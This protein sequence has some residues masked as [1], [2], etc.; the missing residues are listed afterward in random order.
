[1]RAV[2]A[3]AQ[4]ARFQ[5]YASCHAEAREIADDPPSLRT[6]LAPPNRQKAEQAGPSLG[7]PVVQVGRPPRW[8][9]RAAV[10]REQNVNLPFEIFLECA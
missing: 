4:P 3:F 10:Y 1:M 7:R 6:L 5:S 8:R 2:V 9:S